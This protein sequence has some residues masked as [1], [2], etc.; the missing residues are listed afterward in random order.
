MTK[1]YKIYILYTGVFCKIGV[2]SRRVQDRVKEI[3]TNCPLPIHRFTEI[4]TLSKATAFYIENIIKEHLSRHR[5]HGEWY[6][7]IPSIRKTIVFLIHKHSSEEFNITRHNSEHNKFEDISIQLFNKIQTGRKEK[8]IDS[9]SQLYTNFI[10]EENLK[11]DSRFLLYGRDVLIQM[12]E[13]AIGI[14]INAYR[15]DKTI[16]PKSISKRLE[17]DHAIFHET[18]KEFIPKKNWKE[19]LSESTLAILNREE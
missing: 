16:I 2:T 6:K 18:K 4:G 8:N 10:K 13:N 1:K 12:L 9:L 7:E 17:K 19:S 11:D 5:T 3:Q 14:T 15:K